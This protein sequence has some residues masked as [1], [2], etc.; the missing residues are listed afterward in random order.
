PRDDGPRALRRHERAG[1][2]PADAE[3]VEAPV[4]RLADDHD[5]LG[6][7]ALLGG[8]LHLWSPGARPGERGVDVRGHELLVERD[9]E[10]RPHLA[11][12]LDRVLRALRDDQIVAETVR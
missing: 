6:P 10:R 1:D 8:V 3:V 9:P 2:V 11:P 4:D 5:D 7:V 12:D